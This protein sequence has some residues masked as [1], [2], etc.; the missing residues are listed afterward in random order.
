MRLFN[1]GNPGA[2]QYPLPAVAH[3]ECMPWFVQCWRYKFTAGVYVT[4]PRMVELCGGDTCPDITPVART[5][6]MRRDIR[7]LPKHVV[8]MFLEI[9]LCHIDS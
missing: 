5:N 3:I 8:P 4:M 6:K 1:C 2:S 9:I 7:N